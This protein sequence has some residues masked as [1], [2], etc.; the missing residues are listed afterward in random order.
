MNFQNDRYTLRLA[1]PADNDGIRE[2][3]ESGS[4]S[5][6]LSVQYLRPEPLAS[7]AADGDEARI[8]VVRDNERER[9]AAVGGAVVQRCFL[10]GDITRCSYLTGLKIHSDYR[11]HIFFIAR[12][13]KFLGK[14]LSDCTCCYTTIL[15]DNTPVIR[16]MEKR[17][18]NM[19]EYRYIGHY[20]TFCF[21][22]A[23]NILPV[24]CGMTDGLDRLMK[25]YFSGFALAP[26]DTSL[27]GLGD[28]QFYSL[29]GSDG[30]IIAC[31][32]AGDQRMTKQYRL[33]SYGGIFRPLSHLPTSLLGYPPFPKE[34]KIIDH[35][36]ISFLYIKDNDP[37]LCR[38]FLRTVACMQNNSLLLWGCM[39]DHP[40]YGAMKSVKAVRYGSRLYAV[41]FDGRDAH[42]SGRVG[43]E[44]ALL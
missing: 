5:G 18:K 24:E 11:K 7:F 1:V 41:V 35:G 13:Y 14:Q 39:D 43:M 9:I 44:A 23:K 2:I 3:F 15:D 19:P 42:L 10:D 26:S 34:G 29:R 32:F 40:L 21:N 17:R 30:E 27:R 36:V 4:F 12:A 33:S 31:C 38:R 37:K 22:G 16:M 20:T 6:G 28:K 8:L 25:T